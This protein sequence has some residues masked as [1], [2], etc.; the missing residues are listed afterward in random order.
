MTITCP[1]GHPWV[2]AAGESD[3]DKLRRERDRLTQRIAEKDDEIAHQKL[4]REEAEKSA[5]ARKGVITRL[6][7]RASAGVCPC[8]N[9]TVLQMARHMATKHPG[10]KAEE[11]A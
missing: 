11:V 1:N 3:F 6:K 5:A 9:R 8:C 10:F 4:L 7:N 2:Y